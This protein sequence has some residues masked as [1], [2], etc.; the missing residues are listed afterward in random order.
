[1]AYKGEK[2][3]GIS[4]DND[5]DRHHDGRRKSSIM[6]VLHGDDDSAIEGQLFSMNAIDPAL[7]AKMRLVNQVS[8]ALA[9]TSI[10]LTL[11]GHQSD[12]LDQFSF[13]ALLLE[14]IWLYGRQ[15]DS[16][17]TICDR[18][19]SCGGISTIFRERADLCFVCWNVGRSSFLGQYLF[20]MYLMKSEL[21]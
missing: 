5:I 3:V 7:D 20:F 4:Q 17:H 10:S 2:D 21:T 12:R 11:S 9:S 16:G 1:M 8:P 6:N 13:E 14:R 19:P 15:L 18:W